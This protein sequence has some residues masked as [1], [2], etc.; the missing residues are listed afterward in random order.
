MTRTTLS[1]IAAATALVAVTGVASL[2]VPGDAA[3]AASAGAPARLPVE[4]STLLCPG[5]GLSDLSETT[6]TAVTP[7]GEGTGDGAAKLS[8]ALKAGQTEPAAKPLATLKEAG[9]PV[10]VETDKA[11]APAVI[12]D[13]EKGMAPGFA[14]QQTTEIDAGA[15]R[16]LLGA[17]C[18]APD[19]EFWFPAV[20]LAE[21]RQD[22]VYLTNPDDAG[23]VVDL[24]LY[25]P[26]GLIS[27]AD[28]EQQVP[29]HGSSSVLLSTLTDEPL[30]LVT[31]KVTV[32][33]GRVGAAVRATDDKLGGDWLQPAA[34][35]AAQVVLPGI[36]KDATSVR[37]VAFAPGDQ[38]AELGIKYSGPTGQI[39]PAGNET[40]TVKS[41]MTASVDFTGLTAGEGGSLIL[42]PAEGSTAPVVAALR[43]TR[44]KGANQETAF[45]PAT[46]AI[47]ERA[48]AAGSWAVSGKAGGTT[49][50]LTAPDAEVKVKVTATDGSKG[51]TRTEKTY[52]VKAGTTLTPT[53]LPV[54]DGKLGTGRY[55]LTVEKLSGGDLYAARM[56]EQKKDGVP[57]FTVQTL[58]DD[59]GT[60]AVPKTRQDISLLG[61]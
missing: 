8:A 12:G 17:R 10:Y 22:H 14:V 19:T 54:P 32:R 18:T 13:A 44:G 28:G 35:P 49:L 61:D 9:K 34:D 29:G 33:S 11:N 51:G 36:P 1:L 46:E 15:G 38:D 45:I 26:E 52:T 53:D 37:L 24:E 41:G 27:D 50:A 57:M 25:G 31:L 21:D 20:S 2:T 42:R 3:P 39:T 16:G 23:A 40:L 6:Y 59:H 56:L 30:E 58:P 7:G 47:A 48:T 5:A 43:V 55:A 60:V 4:R